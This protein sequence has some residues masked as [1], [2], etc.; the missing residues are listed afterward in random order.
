MSV[1]NRRTFLIRTATAAGGL[2][3]TAWLLEA[4]S[5]A[6]SAT[7]TS[8]PPAAAAPTSAAAAPT[9]APAA[10]PTAGAPTV[11]PAV[12]TPTAAATG[13]AAG[14]PRQG[15]TLVWAMTSDPVTLAPFGVTNTS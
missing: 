11:A 5:P 3:G 7:P 2:I 4:C 10:K 9:S 13:A 1:L 14:T 12:A 15:G 6:P 8:P